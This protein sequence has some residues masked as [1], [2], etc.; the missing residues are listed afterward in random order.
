[1]L[2]HRPVCIFDSIRTLNLNLTLSLSFWCSHTRT[3]THTYACC[4]CLFFVFFVA[5]HW[6]FESCSFAGIHYIW[7]V[8]R[9]CCCCCCFTR[10]SLQI[11][12]RSYDFSLVDDIFIFVL[13]SMSFNLVH[14]HFNAPTSILVWFPPFLFISFSL[15]LSLSLYPRHFLATLFFSCSIQC[16]FY[17]LYLVRFSPSVH[18][19]ASLA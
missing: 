9:R 1:M 5:L 6:C 11:F 18:L 19:Y 16:T 7:C 10:C 12:L 4:F 8:C 15:S 13:F 3:R 2:F 14:L 17:F